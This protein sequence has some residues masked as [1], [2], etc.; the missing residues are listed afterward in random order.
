MSTGIETLPRSSLATIF[1]YGAVLDRPDESQT[2][3]LLKAS[4]TSEDYTYS[5]DFQLAISSVSRRWRTIALDDATLWSTL[6]FRTPSDIQKARLFIPRSRPQNPSAIGLTEM[7]YPDYPSQNLLDI[8]ILTVAPDEYIEGENLSRTELAEIFNT[9]LIPET[10]RWR[11]FHLKVRDNECRIQA[12]Q[13]LAHDCGPAPNL[14]TLQLYHFQDYEDAED[15]WNTI[16]T[17]PRM[18]FRN[19]VP[20]LRHISLV[21]VNLPW[22]SS[23]YLA[24]LESLELALHPNGIRPP[25][26]C[27]EMMLRSP[28][29]KNLSI[30]YSG[31]REPE[32]NNL[33]LMWPAPDSSRRITLTPLRHLRLVDLDP[34]YLISTLELMYL[35][36]VQKLELDLVQEDADYSDFLE[37]CV[38]ENSD[39]SSTSSSVEN[40]LGWTKLRSGL[41]PFLSSLTSLKLSGLESCSFGAF[42]RFIYSAKGLRVLEINFA[43]VCPEEEVWRLFIGYDAGDMG[44]DR[45]EP[46]EGVAETDAD[47]AEVE[48]KGTSDDLEIKTT[49]SGGVEDENDSGSQGSDSDQE[50]AA[51]QLVAPKLDIFRISGLSGKRIRSI[52]IYRESVLQ[53]RNMT[54]GATVRY[55]VKYTSKMVQEDTVLSE[56]VAKG[57]CWFPNDVDPADVLEGEVEVDGKNGWKVVIETKLEEEEE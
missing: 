9:L 57:Y 55:V 38:G 23:P 1:R 49:A 44:T 46:E 48:L 8:L 22:Q 10:L 13:A 51:L 53:L 37:L 29:L 50:S 47:G 15:L 45:N 14:E 35:S 12:R 36:K 2:P 41:F 56:L 18:L 34:E 40:L 28:N 39:T 7:G 27:W 30:L 19:I 11:S 25:Y 26:E 33:T 5:P 43:S 54:V 52:I 17:P 31:P 6:H 32:A 20:N 21:G 3:F 4:N 24:E 42:K 16:Q